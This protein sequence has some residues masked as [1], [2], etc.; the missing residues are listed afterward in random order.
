[1]GPQL[2]RVKGVLAR[3][4]T[5]KKI[6]MQGV[7]GNLEAREHQYSEWPAAAGDGSGA[8]DEGSGGDGDSGREAEA[9]SQQQRVCQVVLIGKDVG[10]RR[11]ALEESCSAAA[12]L[13]LRAVFA[14]LQGPDPHAPPNVR[15]LLAVLVVALMLRPQEEM[16]QWA[17]NF[18]PFGLGSVADATGARTL[19]VLLVQW[20]W[21]ILVAVV[22]G[23]M[24]KRLTKK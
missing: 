4:G 18:D 23:V 1:M 22:S 24:L 6:I 13:P 15:W 9:Q 12:K 10:Q 11:Q 20:R 7:H 5:D 14:E 19:L 2:Y 21:L 16:A 3:E 8:G 17:Q